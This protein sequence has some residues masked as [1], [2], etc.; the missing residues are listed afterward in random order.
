M[1][2]TLA[3]LSDLHATP[4]RVRRLT[5]LA[6]KQVLGWLKWGL[7]RSKAHRPEVLEALVADLRAEQPDHVAITGDLTNL[8]L[9]DE[10]A[11]AA[12]WLQKLGDRRQ[13]SIV[14]GNHDAYVSAL[15]AKTWDCWAG[16]LESDA[17]PDADLTLSR[18]SGNEPDNGF[19]SVRIRGPVALIGVSSARPVG[20]FRASGQVG[21]RQLAKLEQVL[22]KLADSALY[23]V[24]LIHHPPIAD[25]LA[26]RRRLTDAASLCGVLLRT[27]ADLVLHGH[28][29]KTTRTTVP[30]PAGPIPVVGVRSASDIGHRLD[31]KAQYHLYRITR[32]ED[33]HNAR[34]FRV[35]MI[36]RSYDSEHGRF[37]SAGE[38]P[39]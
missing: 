32:R 11:A 13:V 5:S 4:V 37:V 25:G 29:H 28:T 8:G 17:S 3:H 27:G 21:A 33:G 35:I 2:F 10:F 24:V 34:G 18:M 1:A 30:G 19:P 39:L 26:P 16:Y 22:Q 9:A 23:R 7:Q 15:Q 12:A 20:L 38:Y 36:T 14:P 6:P 31:R